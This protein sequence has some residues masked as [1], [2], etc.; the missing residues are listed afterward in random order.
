MRKAADWADDTNGAVLERQ[1]ATARDAAAA[2]DRALLDEVQA[3]N[4]LK[5]MRTSF[6]AADWANDTS[7][8]A[9]ERQCATARDAAA[10]H[11]RSR[12]GNRS[13]ARH[14]ATLEATT[15][16]PPPPPSFPP[17]PSP[18]PA[19]PPP[20]P[21]DTEL[22]M[23]IQRSKLDSG[24]YTDDVTTLQWA[25]ERSL[26]R[27]FVPPPPHTPPPPSPSPAPPPPPPILRPPSPPR[28]GVPF[29]TAQQPARQLA[30]APPGVAV[31]VAIGVQLGRAVAYRPRRPDMSYHASTTLTLDRAAAWVAHRSP[32][33]GRGTCCDPT[34][35][36]SHAGASAAGNLPA[37]TRAPSKR[38]RDND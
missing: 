15:Q 19:P 1:W 20:P 10:A 8:A 2:H 31:G 5:D 38:P 9:P 13:T 25:T 21:E 26:W 14:A 28:Y 33:G 30:D 34:P 29:G 32:P 17:P 4:A 35:T 12:F 7:G 24:T 36:A 11:D 3:R 18:S 23:A 22:D 27:I 37:P 16:L 6:E